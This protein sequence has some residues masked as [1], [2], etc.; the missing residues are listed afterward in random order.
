MSFADLPFKVGHMVGGEIRAFRHEKG[1]AMEDSSA[2]RRIIVGTPDPMSVL[3]ILISMLEPPLAVTLVLHTPRGEEQAG[4]YR[5]KFD[6]YALNELLGQIRGLLERDARLDFSVES[7][8]GSSITYDKHDLILLGG[9]LET[10]LSWL[11]AE[12]F[13]PKP[14]ELPYPHTHHY[15]QEFD[16]DVMALLESHDWE[17]GPLLPGDGD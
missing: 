14:I 9:P 4:R 10:W 2:G 8:S 3:P 6:R 13:E 5:A 15:R 16:L 12:G 7:A 1:F 11:E 17:A